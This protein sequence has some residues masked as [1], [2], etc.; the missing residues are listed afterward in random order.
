[1]SCQECNKLRNTPI[2]FQLLQDWFKMSAD[3]VTSIF[4]RKGHKIF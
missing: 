3:K 1:M 4:H 2:F